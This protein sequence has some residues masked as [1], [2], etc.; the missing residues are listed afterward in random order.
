MPTT[1]ITQNDKIKQITIIDNIRKIKTTYI[2]TINEH[3]KENDITE[4]SVKII[5]RNNKNE[6]FEINYYFLSNLRFEQKKEY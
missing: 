5:N 3:E 4:S 2:P 6:I 1:L